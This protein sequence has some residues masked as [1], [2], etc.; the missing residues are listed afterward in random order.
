M[1]GACTLYCDNK[2][3][4]L[5]AFGHKRPTPRWASYDLI[6]QIRDHLRQSSPI[7]WHFK[8]VKG[9]QDRTT[10]FTRLPY[11][12]QGNV[13]ANFFAL[14]A[15]RELADMPTPA[16][17]KAWEVRIN[18]ALICG[19]LQQWLTYEINKPIMKD[20]WKQ[21]LCPTVDNSVALN[22]GSIFQC[23]TYHPQNIQIQVVKY[24]TRTLPVGKNLKR[25][26]HAESEACPCCGELEDHDHLILCM[27]TSL[28]N[29]FEDEYD[30]LCVWMESNMSETIST[31]IRNLLRM[32]RDKATVTDACHPIQ[33]EQHAVGQW[34]FF[35]RLWLQ[36]W[37]QQLENWYEEQGSKR[38]VAKWITHLL[39]RIQL[40]P[41]AMWKMRNHIKHQTQDNVSK[42]QQH[43]HLDECI[44]HI[45]WTRP[46][47]RL[48][49]HCVNLY[50]TKHT[51]DTTKNMKLQ[52]K[53]NWVTGA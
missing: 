52:R 13:L 25:R 11:D 5:A 38:A 17:S 45:F 41:L 12:A 21:L 22:W 26:R 34:A 9:H 30:S 1:Q 20:R 32:Y 29:T 33:L 4:L 31:S 7:V 47:P 10:K 14:Q 19:N 40:I 6:R 3:A 15:L 51:K 23:W 48:M 24:L 46:H 18:G 16:T 2:G 28:A 49:A 39:R 53:T 36:G 37:E 42:Q 35:A 44:D 27:R 8:H 50:F 43:E